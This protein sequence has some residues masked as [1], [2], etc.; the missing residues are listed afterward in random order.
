MIITDTQYLKQT[1][2]DVDSILEAQDIYI[3]LIYEVK[4]HEIAIGLSAI[5]IGI[6]KQCFITL[7]K[8]SQEKTTVWDYYIN[9]KVEETESEIIE[10]TESCLSLG[11]KKFLVKRPKQITISTLSLDNFEERSHCVLY[12]QDATIFSHELDHCNGTLISDI[13]TE[14]GIPRK[15]KQIGRNEKC[16]CQSGKKF[17]HCCYGKV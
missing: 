13:G 6:P 10:S 12:D 16:S 17:K 1:S 14:L 9:P 8:D 3:K 4:F 11:K 7:R 2:S 5:Q 15:V